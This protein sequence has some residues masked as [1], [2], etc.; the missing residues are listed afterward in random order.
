MSVFV[1][2]EQGHSVDEARLAALA[3]HVLHSENISEDA[4]LSVLLVTKDHMRR[5]NLRFAN[6]DQPTDVL[7]FPMMEDDDEQGSLIGDVVLCPEVAQSNATSMNHSLGHEMD[8]LMVHGTLHLLGYDH[9][10]PEEKSQMDTRLSG[11]LDSFV[12]S[13]L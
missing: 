8:V 1:A 9:Q 5:L 13:P 2:N 6:E 3:G 11:L 12:V 4:E 7:A 10:N